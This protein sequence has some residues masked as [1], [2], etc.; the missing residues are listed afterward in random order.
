VSVSFKF[1][2]VKSFLVSNT[3]S[4]VR[5][6][7]KFFQMQGSQVSKRLNLAELDK[8]MS[9]KERMQVSVIFSC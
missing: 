4:E 1:L 9:V 6:K 3:D 2:L 7:I 8:S 5:K